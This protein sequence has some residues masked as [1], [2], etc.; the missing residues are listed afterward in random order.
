MILWPLETERTRT[1]SAV[2]LYDI[3]IEFHSK[4]R[5]DFAKD[6]GLVRYEYNT[7]I[8][9]SALKSKYLGRNCCRFVR[10]FSDFSAVFNC[11]PSENFDET[12]NDFGFR[13]KQLRNYENLLFA[14]HLQS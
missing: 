8:H 13:T 6:V 2:Y 5:D 12:K 7:H 14:L 4:Q 1:G 10:I 3:K 9:T 11:K